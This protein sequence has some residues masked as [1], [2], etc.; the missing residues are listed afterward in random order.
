MKFIKEWA[1]PILIAILLAILINKFIF[2]NV[3]VP[4]KSMYPTITPGDK[5][6]VLRTY[7][8]SSIKRGDILVFHSEEI[9]KDLIK[10]VIGLPGETVEVKADGNVFIDGELLEEEYVSSFSDKTGIF[11]IPDNCYLF[12]GD[13]RGNSVDARSWENP[14]IP[15][16]DIK[17]EA[18]FILFPFN[19]IGVLK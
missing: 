16:D 7:R 15:F 6:F 12:F 3:G 2:F 4:T 14:Y 10:R 5:I 18:Q 9:N 8:P 17:G 1:I 11:K 19:R 13:N